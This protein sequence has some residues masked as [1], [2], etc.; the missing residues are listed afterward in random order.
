MLWSMGMNMWLRYFCFI[1]C[2][3]EVEVGGM[4]FGGWIQF[5]RY[6]WVLEMVLSGRPLVDSWWDMIHEYKLCSLMNIG[7]WKV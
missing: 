1:L 3:S 5:C 2:R 6:G 7:R 4:T